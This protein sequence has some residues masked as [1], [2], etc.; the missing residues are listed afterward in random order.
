MQHWDE[1]T[2]GSFNGPLDLLLNLIREKKM[3]LKDIS[4]MAVTDQYLAYLQ[5]Q[6]TL[7]IEIASEYL[8]MAA[9]LIEMKSLYLLPQTTKTERDDIYLDLVDQLNQYDQFKQVA[10]LLISKQDEYWQTLSKKP[11]RI[12]PQKKVHQVEEDPEIELL[13][14]DLE[15]FAKLYSRLLKESYDSNVQEDWLDEPASVI[16]TTAISPQEIAKLILTL[17]KTDQLKAW[18]LE[19]LIPNETINLKNL[20]ATFLAILDLVRYQFTKI[21]QQNE[22]LWVRLTT[23]SLEDE[24]LLT[25]LEMMS[26]ENE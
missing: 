2:I 13:A 23:T 5:V 25:R 22:T 16:E 14:F 10:S 24:N 17:M 6:Q 12:E 18:R 8:T 21:T 1:L 11:S 3:S 26:H 15:D 9:Q 20:V 7:D 4:V 19:E